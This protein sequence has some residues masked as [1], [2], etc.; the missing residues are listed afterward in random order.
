MRHARGIRKNKPRLTSREIEVLRY[1][2]EGYKYKEIARKLRIRVKTVQT[3]RT[4]MNRKLNFNSLAKLIHYA[5]RT[6][7]IEIKKEE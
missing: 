3:H 6:G 7:L 2:A 5:V 1:I 4:N